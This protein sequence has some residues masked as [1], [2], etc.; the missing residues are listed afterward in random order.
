MASKNQVQL[1]E[2]QYMTNLNSNAITI[3]SKQTRKT[4]TDQSRIERERIAMKYTIRSAIAHEFQ[5]L[6]V[7]E[8]GIMA[9]LIQDFLTKAIETGK[10][11]IDLIVHEI[12]SDF[13]NDL[14]SYFADTGITYKTLKPLSFKDI[15]KNCDLLFERVLNY[16]DYDKDN[17]P[18]ICQARLIAGI[19]INL[20]PIKSGTIDSI[21]V[22][23]GIA[24]IRELESII[25]ASNQSLETALTLA[26]H[27]LDGAVPTKKL[28]N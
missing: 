23:L 12:K 11:P 8:K 1:I 18:M 26:N 19:T 13:L 3:A 22:D 4:L 14:L 20:S 21:S 7:A 28:I 17:I 15:E 6:S 27:L 10:S 25:N 9:L 2:A 5:T 16:H 24:I